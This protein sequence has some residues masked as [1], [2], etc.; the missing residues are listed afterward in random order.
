M[1]QA[2]QSQNLTFKPKFGGCL[3]VGGLGKFTLKF[4]ILFEELKS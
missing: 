2:F 1:I 4:M 3:I